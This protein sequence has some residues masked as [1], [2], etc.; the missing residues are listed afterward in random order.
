MTDVMD[1]VPAE[2]PVSQVAEQ[3]SD[4]EQPRVDVFTAFGI[5]YRGFV[6]AML[7]GTPQTGG[8]AYNKIDAQQ[9]R[10]KAADFA[11]DMVRRGIPHEQ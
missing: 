5:Y 11:Y 4:A 10:L 1:A 3:E 2:D 7:A 6:D 8:H 9:L